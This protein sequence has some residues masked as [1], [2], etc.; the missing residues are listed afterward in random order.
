MI[1][2]PYCHPGHRRSP[3]RYGACSGFCRMID[4]RVPRAACL[5]LAAC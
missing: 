5:R 1:M 3:I 4:L 2:M